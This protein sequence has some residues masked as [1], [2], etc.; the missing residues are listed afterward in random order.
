[1]NYWS[2]EDTYADYSHGIRLIANDVMVNHSPM[3]IQDVFKDATLSELISD[4]G[5]LTFLRY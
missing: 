3:R 5:I 2:H 4:E 1:M